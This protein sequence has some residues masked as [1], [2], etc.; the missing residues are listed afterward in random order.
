MFHA[1]LSLLADRPRLYNPSTTRHH[2][3]LSTAGTFTADPFTSNNGSSHHI[4]FTS[5]SH[6]LLTALATTIALVT[7]VTDHPNHVQNIVRVRQVLRHPL[8]RCVCCGLHTMY[9]CL[10]WQSLGGAR[11]YVMRHPRTAVSNTYAVQQGFARANVA[12]WRV[13][14]ATMQC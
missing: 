6:L 10:S 1:R 13:P 8:Q 9:Y 11:L 3:P 12:H 7:I 2:H 5:A 14:M 4:A